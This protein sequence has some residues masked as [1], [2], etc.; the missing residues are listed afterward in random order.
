MEYL[1]KVNFGVSMEGE[2]VSTFSG[3]IPASVLKT[4]A[5]VTMFIDHF[6]FMV[7]KLLEERFLPEWGAKGPVSTPLRMVGRMAFVIYA[8]LLAE[9]LIYTRNRGRYLLRLLLGAVISE[10]PFDLAV[11][12]KVI[13]LWEQNTFFTLSIGFSVIWVLDE[14]KRTY[15]RTYGLPPGNAQIQNDIKTGKVRDMQKDNGVGSGFTAFGILVIAAGLILAELIRCDYGCMGVGLIVT[16]YLCRWKWYLFPA[17]LIENYF[18]HL[19]VDLIAAEVKLYRYCLKWDKP[20]HLMSMQ[21]LWI[22]LKN[23]ASE[24]MIYTMPG[25]V[26]ALLL[27]LR[28]NGEKGKQ[29]PKAFYYLF[30]PA[31]LLALNGA[32]WVVMRIIRYLF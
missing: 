14:I 15:E 20:F 17:A 31:H 9:G 32:A 27:I 21:N 28:Y 3:G 29:L 10:I 19:L 24:R 5:V 26:A 18:G 22:N 12:G 4:I 2:S 7:V 13:D 25:I 30:Y 16:F 6:A 1:I 11:S 23:F 8:Y